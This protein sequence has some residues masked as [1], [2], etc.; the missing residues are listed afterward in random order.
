[1]RSR[2]CN[3][4]SFLRRFAD[5]FIAELLERKFG[6]TRTKPG[7]IKFAQAV[8]LLHTVVG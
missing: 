5:I 7:N 4:H 8:K 1:M 6:N 2:S 3:L